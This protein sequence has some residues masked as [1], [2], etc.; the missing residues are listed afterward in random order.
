MTWLWDASVSTDVV[1]YILKI[2]LGLPL[3]WIDV[4][5]TPE[6]FIEYEMP[7][8]APGEVVYMSVEAMDAAGDRSDDAD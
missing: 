3:V 4:G 8:P 6:T 7:T 1:A 2:S 5:Q